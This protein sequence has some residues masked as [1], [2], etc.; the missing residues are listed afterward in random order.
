[1]NRDDPAVMVPVRFGVGWTF[2]LGNPAAWL[3]IAGLVAVPAGLALLRL[4]AGL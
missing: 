3:V 1:M 2:N 4:T